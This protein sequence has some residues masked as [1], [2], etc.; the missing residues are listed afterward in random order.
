MDDK[1]F[2]LLLDEIKKLRVDVQT[3]Q[4]DVKVMQADMK[5]MQGDVKTLQSDM[6]T[7]KQELK[8]TRSQMNHR[9]D[10]A[11]LK[12]ILLEDKLDEFKKDASAQFD[13]LVND[14]IER[15]ERRQDHAAVR[16]DRVE[17]DVSLAREQVAESV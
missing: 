6:K 10:T 4:G 7:L 1:K 9:F 17:A 3:M 16:L 2:D 5:T 14:R 8:D 11:E 13:K 12:F 15:L